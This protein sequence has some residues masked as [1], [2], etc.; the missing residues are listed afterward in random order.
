[1]KDVED[2]EDVEDVVV[3]VKNGRPT[4]TKTQTK[5][6]GDF[7]RWVDQG[8]YTAAGLYGASASGDAP[9]H[10]EEEEEEEEETKDVRNERNVTPP[11]LTLPFFDKHLAR[12][13]L[14]LS[15]LAR[16]TWKV[17]L[18]KDHAKARDRIEQ[19][20]KKNLLVAFKHFRTYGTGNENGT[21]TRSKVVMVT[22][23]LKP[24]ASCENAVCEGV[25]GAEGAE[26]GGESSERLRAPQQPV[27]LSCYVHLC[28]V[29]VT[30]RPVKLLLKT[31]EG[32][33]LP[34]AKSVHWAWERLPL[35][36]CLSEAQGTSEVLMVSKNG[37][38]L[39]GMRSNFFVIRKVHEDVKGGE[40][41]DDDV[42]EPCSL[43]IQTTPL[44]DG[45]LPGIVRSVVLDIAEKLGMI[46]LE[47]SPKL[48][49]S[50]LWLESFI[51]SGV[52]LLQPVKHIVSHC[53]S[54]SLESDS[55]LPPLQQIVVEK[56]FTHAPGAW[57]TRIHE[58]IMASVRKS[59]Q[60]LTMPL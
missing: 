30:R 40:D 55:S 23:A 38:I 35:E 17:T 13:H 2:V 58:E 5:T 24:V 29:P 36:K 47:S 33:S 9:I 37:N 45:I 52:K 12:L 20:V 6:P 7:L 4:K 11:P 43:C 15:L 34:A 57:T 44:E 1:M 53:Q 27:P 60:G 49:E 22:I 3:V 42:S 50:E 32:R 48:C 41:E 16:E 56:E 25:E 14:S 10:E 26:G 19:D 8:A 54:Q 21:S 46:T 51:T 31:F 39:E 59:T 28:T 18:E